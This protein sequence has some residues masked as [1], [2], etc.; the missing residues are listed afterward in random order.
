[1]KNLRAGETDLKMSMLQMF[2]IARTTPTLNKMYIIG[3]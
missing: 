1:M 3:G 2:N